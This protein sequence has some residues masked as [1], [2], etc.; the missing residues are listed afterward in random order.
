MPFAHA[1]EIDWIKV[2]PLN[3]KNW[4]PTLLATHR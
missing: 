4:P 1:M 3:D 2:E